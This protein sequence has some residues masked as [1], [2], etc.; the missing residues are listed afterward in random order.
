MTNKK[1][2]VLEAE[3]KAFDD[4]MNQSFLNQDVLDRFDVEKAMTIKGFNWRRFAFWAKNASKR[5][6]RQCENLVKNNGILG[7][8]KAKLSRKTCFV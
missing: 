3:R 5:L 6:F 8:G 4:E 2:K 1:R 7:I